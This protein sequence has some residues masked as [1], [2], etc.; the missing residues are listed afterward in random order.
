MTLDTMSPPNVQAEAQPRKRSH[1]AFSADLNGVSDENSVAQPKKQ[2]LEKPV[3]T[4]PLF[5]NV[6]AKSPT[7]NESP[8]SMI[9]ASL[10]PS[11]SPPPST[12][13]T[14]ETSKSKL[15]TSADKPTSPTKFNGS[16][17]PLPPAP[18][19][20]ITMADAPTSSAPQPP[21]KKSRPK[22]SPAEKAAKAREVEDQKARKEAE[23]NAKAEAKA[24]EDA[25]KEAE[26][27]AKAEAKEAERKKKAE[28]KEKAEAEK[29][30]KA[31]ERA[32]KKRQKD[33]EER[34]AQEAK[35]KKLKA[36]PSIASFFGGAKSAQATTPKKTAVVAS[37]DPS[38]I[39]YSPGATPT[40]PSPE[41]TEYE[42]MFPSF[43][44]HPHVSLADNNFMMDDETKGTMSKMLD[45]FISGSRGEAQV[46]PFKAVDAFSLPAAPKPRGKSHPSVK[47]LMKGL[48]EGSGSF[49]SPVDL[50]KSGKNPAEAVA[51]TL[52]TIPYKVI[53][54]KQDVRPPYRGT[55]TSETSSTLKKLAKKPLSRS[56]SQLDYDYESEAEWY[57]DGEGD[58]L[59]S[60]S[61]DEEDVDA[62]D[63]FDGFLD[64]SEDVGP[65]SRLPHKGDLV[66]E[67]TGICF[68]DETSM[69]PV[70]K[71]YKYRMEFILDVNPHHGIDPFS[72][73]YWPDSR[74]KTEGANSKKAGAS[75]VK[76]DDADEILKGLSDATIDK[77]KAGIERY[78]HINKI[79]LVNCIASE[80]GVSAKKLGKIVMLMAEQTG[81]PAKKAKKTW[82]LR[83]R[84][85]A[86]SATPA[87]AS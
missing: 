62:E 87:P 76:K 40:K 47:K 70:A 5:A 80:V 24:A 38:R 48:F 82:Q 78:N 64:D 55:I 69:G 21:I 19:I 42:R 68:E 63:D 27:I 22:L 54:F 61:D 39:I 29:A 43:Y 17:R 67:S 28:A 26:R 52:K 74:A 83:P 11:N 59:D 18:S 35:E 34:R 46:K 20:E 44:M 53:A 66:P 60:G 73:A 12:R 15:A 32:E 4:H 2:A 58:D 56:L 31:Q 14:T 51:E 75:A 86:S 3:Q 57:D 36:Q 81:P 85:R 72:T 30:A 23:R 7:S 33:E 10:A 8:A 50:T 65:H 49:N 25:R 9:M 77:I 37:A 6:A 45:E 13:T 1:D 79:G 84:F 41:Q 16:R 71:A